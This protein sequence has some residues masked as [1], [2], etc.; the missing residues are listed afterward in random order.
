MEALQASVQARGDT[1][2][3]K[4]PSAKANP[5]ENASGGARPK[6][7]P[8]K[9]A[10][11]E[12]DDGKENPRRSGRPGPRSRPRVTASERRPESPARG[13]ASWSELDQLLTVR[14]GVTITYEVGNC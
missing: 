13:Q 10:D 5:V 6:K 14:Q 9:K 2:P 8:A 11:S 12:T 1:R 3:V 7:V 4:R